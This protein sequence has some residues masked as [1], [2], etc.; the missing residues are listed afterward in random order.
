MNS[1]FEH[2]G[3]CVDGNND[4]DPTGICCCVTRRGE[5]ICLRCK[6]AYQRTG[7]PLSTE[8]TS[9]IPTLDLQDYLCQDRD[10]QVKF[11]ADLTDAFRSFGF[12]SIANHSVPAHEIETAYTHAKALF[13]LPEETKARYTVADSGGARGYTRFGAEHAKDSNAPDL[14]EFWHVGR[15]DVPWEQRDL[16][17]P[18]VWPLGAFEN[19]DGL[20][21]QVFD[22]QGFRHA[23]LDLYTS[24]EILGGVLLQATAEGLGLPRYH[25]IQPV[26]HGDSI[27]RP[28]HYPPIVGSVAEF[29]A[30]QEATS[31][32]SAQHE[33]INVI[34]L[35]VGSGE[36]GL[37]VLSRQGEWIPVATS[38]DTI[39]V[40][41]GDMLQR[42]TNNILRSTTHR[43]V[44][45]PASSP[46]REKARYSIPFFLHYNAEYVLR[47]IQACIDAQDG[48]NH[49][50]E[51]VT[52]RTYLLERL[53][54]IGLLK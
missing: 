7:L 4:R 47:P 1:G 13:A 22:G 46:W 37:E 36:P 32:R 50:P 2:C 34:T 48:V 19:R 41:V 20:V 43:V 5:P 28:I 51:A 29:A 33:D 44:N 39:V 10:R 9:K 27:L 52:A 31:V 26:N 14:K 11:A 6:A 54:E 30:N 8:T 24:L 3:W 38:P 25:F 49:Y 21:T 53:A 15:E 35:L 17:A 42:S 18:N 45:P 23:M 40:N 16:Y 12:V